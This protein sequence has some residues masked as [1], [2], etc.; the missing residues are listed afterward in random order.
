MRKLC[1]LLL[2]V[3]TDLF[4]RYCQVLSIILEIIFIIIFHLLIQIML[5]IIIVEEF[6]LFNLNFIQYENPGLVLYWGTIHM[7]LKGI[8]LFCSAA[9][10]FY[11]L[12][13]WDNLIG[14]LSPIYV[15]TFVHFL[16]L[17]RPWNIQVNVEVKTHHWFTSY[18]SVLSTDC[19]SYVYL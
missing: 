9:F 12:T 1:Y 2:A 14:W 16:F 18:Y 6:C 11:W 5:T 13:M 15:K 19:L 17:I 3:I 8:T 7:E 4:L 10:L